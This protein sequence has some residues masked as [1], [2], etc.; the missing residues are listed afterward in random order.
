MEHIVQFAINVDDVTIQKRVEEK[1]YDDILKKLYE[2]CKSTMCKRSGYNA[3]YID[4]V[5]MTNQALDDFIADH[6]EEIIDQ[7]AEKL[8]NSICHTKAYREMKKD[9]INGL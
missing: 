9:V 7:V 2:D 4:W 6:K 8:K 1:A 5:G 3:R